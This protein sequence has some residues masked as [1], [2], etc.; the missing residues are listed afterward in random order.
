MLI[1]Q[2]FRRFLA[3]EMIGIT[4]LTAPFNSTVAPLVLSGEH[5]RPFGAVG[6]RL[7]SER[8]RLPSVRL[9][10]GGALGARAS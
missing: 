10:A 2:Q 8:D 6:S 9:G 1:L 5:R 3:S 7:L 4:N